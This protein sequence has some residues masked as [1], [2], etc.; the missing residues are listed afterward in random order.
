MIEVREVLLL[1]VL[2]LDSVVLEETELEVVVV[3]VLVEVVEVV[4]VV[5]V[6]VVGSPPSRTTLRLAPGAPTTAVKGPTLLSQMLT[7][8][9]KK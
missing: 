9:P 8:R 6:L 1:V 2:V 3:R 7:P 4:S 5:V